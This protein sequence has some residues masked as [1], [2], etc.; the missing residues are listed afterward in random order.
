MATK[1]INL[2]MV[3]NR[4]NAKPAKDL[5]QALWT[6]HQEINRAVAVIEKILILFRGR[7]Y[8]TK[9]SKGNEITVSAEEVQK[10]AIEFARNIQKVNGGESG[11]DAKLLE[12]M[13][14]LY[15]EIIK[16]DSQ[17]ANKF[18]SPL[19]DKESK[20][21][22]QIFDQIVSPEP[23][24]M[25]MYNN[26]DENYVKESEKWLK[27]S[28]AEALINGKEGVKLRGRKA[29]WLNK[30][31]KSEPWQE[32]FITDQKKK[33]KDIQGAPELIKT[34]KTQWKLLPL[35][36][37]PILS[38]FKSYENKDISPWDRL[39]LRLAV[40]HTLSWESW[41][42]KC[43]QEW[44]KINNLI[45]QQ[46]QKISNSISPE[47]V[48]KIRDYEKARH[49][50]LKTITQTTDDN[51][52][53][54]NL[55]MLRAYDRVKQEWS[56]RD[57]ISQKDREGK[58]A[59]LQ[60]EL[61]GKFGDP[62]LY[63]WLSL[64]ENKSLWFNDEDTLIEIARL[65]NLERMLEKR[66]QQAIMTFA[67]A[68]EHP[69]WAQFEKP[70][71]TNL[72]S[73]EI[74]QRNNGLALKLPLLYKTENGLDEKVFE[75]KLAKSGQINSPQIQTINKVN[76]LRYFYGDEE[77][78]AG[79]SGSDILFDRPFLENR[80][81]DYIQEGN[82]G[83]VW[84]KLVLDI[85]PKAP[86][87]WLDNKGSPKSTAEINHFKSNLLNK[88]H[89][90]ELKEGLRVL[91]LD[92]GIRSFASCS[93]FE[94]VRG[95]PNKGV[96]WPADKDKNLWAK[97]ERSFVISLPG[98][99]IDSKTQLARGAAYEKLS[100]LRQGRNLIRDILRLS[101][102]DNIED[103]KSALDKVV[104]PKDKYSERIR[105]YTVKQEDKSRLENYADKPKAVWKMQVERIYRE[106]ETLISRDISNWRKE[107]RI[108]N[109]ER[110]YCT[111]KSYWGIKYL[112]D[113]RDFLK[114]WS[115][116]GRQYGQ[117]NRIERQ[118][119][120]VFANNLLQH[121]NNK[122]EDRVK[123]GADLIIQSARGK[124]YNENT[125]KW[126]DRFEPCRLILFEDLAMYRFKTDRPRRENSQLMRWSHRAIRDEVEQQSAIYGIHVDTTGAGF[127]SRFYAKNGCPGVRATKITD[128]TLRYISSNDS[129]RKKLF[130][131]GLTESML[132]VGNIIPWEG[133]ELF[134]SYSDREN[135]HMI[136][137]DINAAQNLQRRFWT[138]YSDAF[139][140][141]VRYAY[142]SE[143]MT[144]WV[145]EDRGVR[146]LGGLAKLTDGEGYTLFKSEKDGFS[147]DKLNQ[148]N[149]TK[150]TGGLKE[151]F[152]ESELDGVDEELM[153]AE[154]NIEKE[155]GKN[156]KIF[157]RD[158]SG[159]VLN[160]D[161]FYP[162]E[163][164]WPTVQRKI[165]RSLALKYEGEIHNDPTP[166]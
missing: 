25:E 154:S 74:I 96:F 71:G 15:L 84:F 6:T 7:S 118:K 138:R 160:K 164:F 73:Y 135:L 27:S 130:E 117:K 12:V 94:L 163:V 155:S 147:P 148:K 59:E 33:K 78:R 67:D 37:P 20:G 132:K 34:L 41:N 9:D 156:R 70:G 52:F 77:Y 165:M 16:G 43:K 79:F 106:Y 36:K 5:R 90:K 114:G 146:I 82:I 142:E 127:S 49:E 109:R 100:E 152:Q 64:E 149:W 48:D 116:H 131:N 133:G 93:V 29:G 125:K 14:K 129:L 145:N 89:Q 8:L 119:S 69:R 87:E 108:K 128:N 137:A 42:K 110:Q 159:L 57:C 161:K 47:L 53:K 157:F 51:I 26:D 44:E 76:C 32:S 124:I 103:R 58:L 46:K 28:Q 81:I 22:M 60:T 38:K 91:T 122:K 111:G 86:T 10:K 126:E 18:A 162:T 143:G 120:G 112:E 62:D 24:W 54:I 80:E 95:K 31:A 98:E 13:E 107:T 68:R 56:K 30:L 1:T 45:N 19:M 140:V 50:Y 134:V 85:E 151:D 66:R 104:N 23:K 166:F 144:V 101:V 113:V 92:L 150:L 11:S 4:S 97:H 17:E 158:A 83:S 153:D 123:S 2:K 99:N 105:K 75:I 63:K 40:A 72:K 21:L 65:N 55:R 141:K 39:A 136:H 61:K 3:L 121:I 115:T 35:L 102:I 88:K 139:R